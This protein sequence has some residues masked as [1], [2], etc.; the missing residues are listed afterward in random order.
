[1]AKKDQKTVLLVGGGTG[2]HFLPIYRIYQK[3]KQNQSFRTF[4]VGSK[5]DL[6]IRLFNGNSD[7]IFLK[8]GKLHRVLTVRNLFE[9]IYL[10]FGFFKSLAI[11]LSLRPEVI[12]SKGG[13]VALPLIVWARILKIPYLVHESD[14]AIGSSNRFVASGAKKVFSG[15]PVNN[16]PKKFRKKMFFVG[17]IVDSKGEKSHKA[18]FDFGFDNNKPVILVT[19][20]SQGAK[21]LNSHLLDALEILLAKY[22]V[23]HQTGELDYQRVINFRSK[24]GGIL[25][26]SYFVTDYLSQKNGI[27]M[28]K[29]AFV[30]ADLVVARAGATTI[31]EIALYKKPMILIPYKHASLDHQRK[32]AEF[33]KKEKAAVV[34]VEDDLNEKRLR[35]EIEDLI[36]NKKKIDELTKKAFTIFPSTA[37][38]DIVM[39]IKEEVK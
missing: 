10:C 34:I 29:E 32:N 12:F 8:T 25:K 9:F 14:I 11:I 15:F 36:G 20:G 22:N 18:G 6:E 19:G 2:G 28:M 30:N 16:Y 5:S 38:D 33:M 23:I 27:D 35:A 26:S 37:L 31:A 39:A 7:Y 21:N 17:Q 24:L 1:M 4:V 3:L 13:Y